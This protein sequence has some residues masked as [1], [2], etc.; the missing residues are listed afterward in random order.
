MRHV[1]LILILAALLPMSALAAS[2]SY[3]QRKKPEY[4]L[5]AEQRYDQARQ[6]LAGARHRVAQL[7]R[8]EARES[9]AAMARVGQWVE[10]EELWQEQ[11]AAKQDLA[12]A[13]AQLRQAFTDLN[14]ARDV[15]RRRRVGPVPQPEPLSDPFWAL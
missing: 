10:P 14:R 2:P 4:V 5:I 15:A 11:L 3:P 13:K 9:R 1:K 12:I 6:T 8:E 7:R